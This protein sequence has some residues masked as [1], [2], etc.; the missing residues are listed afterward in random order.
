[1]IFNVLLLRRGQ[2]DLFKVDKT[3][4]PIIFVPKTLQNKTAIGKKIIMKIKLI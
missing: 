2:F 3:S 4:T 1:M